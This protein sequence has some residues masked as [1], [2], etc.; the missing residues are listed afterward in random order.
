MS[1]FTTYFLYGIFAQPIWLI[2]VYGITFP[3]HIA[4]A[5]MHPEYK[6][7]GPLSLRF[8]TF[9]SLHWVHDVVGFVYAWMCFLACFFIIRA[10]RRAK[11][12][13]AFVATI[14][15]GK[16]RQLALRTL[17]IENRLPGMLLA[18]K[19]EKKPTSKS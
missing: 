6:E 13:L 11:S 2:V 10:F 19:V 4:F 8:A 14:D 15:R 7:L 5:F 12:G 18:L 3:I 1:K 16:E 17:M 9:G